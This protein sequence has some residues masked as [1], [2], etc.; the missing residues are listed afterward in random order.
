LALNKLRMIDVGIPRW[1]TRAMEVHKRRKGVWL[2]ERDE[3]AIAQIQQYFGCE[4]ESA[5]VRLALRVL[6]QNPHLR[7]I[8]E[9]TFSVGGLQIV[10]RPESKSKPRR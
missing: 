7:I 10:S 5:A 6:A 2:D 4:S 8:Q 3:A 9:D 1:Y